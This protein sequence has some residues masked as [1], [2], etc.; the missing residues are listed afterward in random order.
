MSVYM[1]GNSSEHFIIFHGANVFLEL[2]PIYLISEESGRSKISAKL[3]INRTGKQCRERYKNHLCPEIKKGDWTPAEDKIIM[4]MKEL[5]GNHWTRIAKLLPGRSDNAVKN[6]WH[7]IERSRAALDDDSEDLTAKGKRS[8][9]RM[10]PQVSDMSD[11]DESSSSY[12]PVEDV[13]YSHSD[14][15]HSLH[16]EEI[17]PTSAPIFSLP[18]DLIRRDHEVDCSDNSSISSNSR[19]LKRTHS[20]DLL[21]DYA[22]PVSSNLLVN[23]EIFDDLETKKEWLDDCWIDDFIQLPSS[24][25]VQDIFSGVHQTVPNAVVGSPSFPSLYPLSN[26]ESPVISNANKLISTT[27]RGSILRKI[28]RGLVN[29]FS[30]AV[31]A[32]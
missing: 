17:Y 30:Q 9:T 11:S 12:I 1:F 15:D 20:L 23:E 31:L 14:H 2:Y 25:K 5:L 29:G 3:D 18:I 32:N 26:L 10:L 6:R 27:P 13:T 4:E 8:C 16:D 24:H 22:P 21:Q 19:C 28:R 7:L